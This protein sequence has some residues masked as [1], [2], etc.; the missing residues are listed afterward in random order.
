VTPIYQSGWDGVGISLR[1]PLGDNP[2]SIAE[3]LFDQ[4]ASVIRTETSWGL[5]GFVGETKQ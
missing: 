4:A 2:R 3:E 5:V 1:V